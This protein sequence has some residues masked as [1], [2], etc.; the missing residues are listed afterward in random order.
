[1]PAQVHS[2]RLWEIGAAPAGS[3]LGAAKKPLALERACPEV[4][5]NKRTGEN[6]FYYTIL[7]HSLP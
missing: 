1:M 4:R 5:F 3:T 6:K 7:F 2:G